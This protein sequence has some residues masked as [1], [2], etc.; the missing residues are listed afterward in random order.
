MAADTGTPHDAFAAAFEAIAR[1]DLDG[2]I[3]NLSAAVRGFAAA[4]DVKQEA[5]ACA[6]LGKIFGNYMANRV[7]ATPWFTRAARLLEN[8]PPCIEQGLVALAPMGCD[9]DD[10]A[11]LLARAELALGLARRFGDADLEAKALADGGLAL[12]QAGRHD[13]GMALLD[14][15]MALICGSAEQS[16][17]HQA[18]VCSFFTACYYTADFGRFEAWSPLLRQ[19]GLL[20]D[21]PGPQAVLTSHCDSVQG[22]LLCQLGQWAEAESVLERALGTIEQV[23]PMMAWHPPIALAELRVLQGRLAEAEALL[24]GRDDHIQALLPMARLHL[25]RGDFDLARAAATRGLK[26]MGDDRVRASMVLGVLVEAEL[27]R[28]DVAAAADASR[29]LD[30]R[31]EGAQHA[32]ITA[33][34][35]RLRARVRATEGDPREAA[36]IIDA[37]VATLDRREADL[38]LVRAR[39]YVDLAR[40]HS[41]LGDEASAMVAAKA[42]AAVLT[43]ADIDLPPA[44]RDV[45]RRLGVGG[46]A[47][48]VT[49]GPAGCRVASLARDGSWWTAACGDTKV[50]L[51][52]TKGL[53]YLAELVGHP[54]VER[55]VVDLVDQVEK[56]AP[57]GPRDLRRKVGGDLGPALD[58]SARDEYRR[59]VSDLRDEIEDAL[60]AEDD[61]RAAALQGELFVLLQELSRAFGLGGRDRATGTVAEKARLNVTRAVRAAITKVAEALPEA[62]AVL[63]RRVRT[64]VFCAYEPHPDD[65][66]L[67]KISEVFSPD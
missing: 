19:R 67:W 50:R 3:V 55:H 15:G 5:M 18:A 58:R 45:L 44:D 46:P 13:E 47:E 34:A 65:P 22:V 17:P 66:V 4:G 62:G 49:E 1:F 28:G 57:D 26:L 39:L 48:A 35:A 10:P 12:V 60:A 38:P 31:V 51:K 56:L 40:F 61:E 20:G 29:E 11:V 21:A 7:A 25:A 64:G 33:E 2:A 14:E 24:L 23:M 37:T 59:R 52:H 42:A 36:A 27:G 30:R 32:P 8:E 43:R 63:D 41:Q 9:V 16:E 54:G 53:Q 6:C